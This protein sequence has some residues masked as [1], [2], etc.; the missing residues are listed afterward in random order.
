MCLFFTP[1]DFLLSASLFR[2]CLF[3]HFCSFRHNSLVYITVSFS[4][5]LP[6]F[7]V[8]RSSSFCSNGRLLTSKIFFS[9]FLCFLFFWQRRQ[10]L[11]VTR[12]LSKRVVFVIMITS[13]A[14][15]YFK[16][17]VI[18]RIHAL[19]FCRIKLVFLLNMALDILVDVLTLKRLLET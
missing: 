9:M 15:F 6:P 11:S 10:L 3:F 4:V 16:F 18:L 14:E 1:N 5:F 8:A 12:S 7:R 17:P 13:F 2:F 19:S